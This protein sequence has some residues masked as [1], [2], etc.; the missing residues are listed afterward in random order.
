MSTKFE[1]KALLVGYANP[2]AVPEAVAELLQAGGYN[3]SDLEA[4]GTAVPGFIR[5]DR[6]KTTDGYDW[7]LAL[8]FVTPNGEICL[9]I[10]WAQD[11]EKEDGTSL[12]RLP[13]LYLKGD[14]GAWEMAG[15][16]GAFILALEGILAAQR[17]AAEEAETNLPKLMN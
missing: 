6:P 15:M 5:V 12:D 2:E 9:A 8:Y 17:L 16:L 14:V 13:A 1:E 3:G 11:W 7:F 4:A 10:P